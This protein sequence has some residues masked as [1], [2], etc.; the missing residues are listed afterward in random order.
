[1]KSLGKFWTHRVSNIDNETHRGAI[2]EGR[3]LYNYLDQRLYAGS[4]TEWLKVTTPYDIFQVGTSVIFS[5]YPL[6]DNWTLEKGYAGR[7]VMTTALSGS[8]ATSGGTWDITGIQQDGEHNHG[9][10]TGGPTDFSSLAGASDIYAYG[11]KTNHR[12]TITMDG[13]HQ[14]SFTGEWR[15]KHT[16]SIVATYT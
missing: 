9:G 12:H 4:D 8:I 16:H 15:P 11:S 3:V 6:P 13:E 1:M 14:H 7:I 2:D 10:K 5:S